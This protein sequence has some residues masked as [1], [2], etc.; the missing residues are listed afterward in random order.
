MGMPVAG[1]HR[2]TVSEVVMP[3]SPNEPLLPQLV[4]AK[5]TLK[6]AL[7]NACDADIDRANT[8]ELIRI[9]QTLA[10]ANEAAKHAVSVRRRLSSQRAANDDPGTAN[11]GHRQIEDDRGVRW[12]V[13]AVRP[14][15]HEGRSP[16][17]ERFRDGWLTFDSG[18]ETRRVAP[19]PVEWELLGPDELLR[20][21]A[22]AETAL[23]RV[24]LLNS[25][26]DYKLDG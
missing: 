12:D 11:S 1:P 2:Q 3:A 5:N 4:H 22:A 24:R 13:F 19:I 16:V 10:I 14:S 6:S 8:G 26:P 20:L 18:V 9:E 15:Q 17:Q 25:P 21:C 7:A 23:R